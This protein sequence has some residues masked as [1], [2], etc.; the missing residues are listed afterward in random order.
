MNLCSELM[1]MF[2]FVANYFEVES[3]RC[4]DKLRN[5][6][7]CKHNTVMGSGYCYAHLLYRHHLRIKQSELE[8]AGLGL[9]AINPMTRDEDVIVFNKGQTIIEYMGEI[10]DRDELLERYDEHT[11]PYTVGI[12][13]DRY[14]DAAKVRGV[15]ALANTYPK[16]NNAAQAIYRGK[17]RLKATRNIYNGEEI[18]LSYGRQY[19]LHEDD[20][21]HETRKVRK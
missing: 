4:K 17:A 12:S 11:A 10:V 19:K 1:E 5:G 13:K 14:E 6:F 16:H 9:F 7:Q 15:G 20:V 8:D 2:I 18:Y 21:E 3:I